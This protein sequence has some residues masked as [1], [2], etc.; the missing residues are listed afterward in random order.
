[1]TSNLIDL[2]ILEV[3]LFVMEKMFQN[4]NIPAFFIA[5]PDCLKTFAKHNSKHSRIDALLQIATS[6]YR[7]QFFFHML[8]TILG[9][10]K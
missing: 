10:I 9:E 2:P 8:T 6:D 1:M 5:H 3:R 7:D 4:G